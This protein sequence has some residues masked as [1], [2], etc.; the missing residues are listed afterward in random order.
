MKSLI[1]QS[2]PEPTLKRL[3]SYYSYLIERIGH[4]ATTISCT[5]IAQALSLNSIQVRKDLQM[6][7]AQGKPRI[8]YEI[9]EL[10]QIIADYLGYNNLNEAVLIGVG[11]FGKLIIGYKGFEKYGL[12][13]TLAFD[14]NKELT[15]KIINGVKVLHINR[16]PN[17]VKRLNIKIAILTTTSENASMTAEMLVESG[18][19]AIWN[20]THTK[21]EISKDIIVVDVNL[22]ES[23]SILLSKLSNKY[24]DKL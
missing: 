1:I 23:L 14:N 11:N 8:G 21:L 9:R 10:S 17:L 4:G 3:P 13:I 24:K 2:I 12:N 16:L 19:E 5:D 18:I 22:E 7:G 20:M 6:A 15:D